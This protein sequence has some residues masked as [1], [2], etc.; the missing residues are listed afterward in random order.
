VGL[1]GLALPL[2]MELSGLEV[3]SSTATPTGLELRTKVDAK[4]NG[5][6]PWCRKVKGSVEWANAAKPS[7]TLPNFYCN[8][9]VIGNVSMT[10]TLTVDRV[11]TANK[12]FSGKYTVRFVGTRNAFGSGD[13]QA[14]L[15]T[16]NR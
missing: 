10:M 16:E 15:V 4:V 3:Q 12:T 5:I 7:L 9:A 8:W 1:G 13:F 2:V 14:N 6:P 11:D